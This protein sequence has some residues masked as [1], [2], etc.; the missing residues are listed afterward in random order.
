MVKMVLVNPPQSNSLDDH[1]DPPLGLMY[2]AACLERRSMNVSICDLSAKSELK[3]PDL[4]PEADIYGLTVFS[5][6]L[7]VSRRISRMIKERYRNAKIIAGGPHPTSLPEETV[8]YGEFDNVVVGEGEEIF[9]RIVEDLERGLE[10]PKVVHA[11]RIEDLDS[12]PFPARH[13]VD[14]TG[15]HREV[16]DQKATSIISSRGCAWNCNFCCKDV[17]GRKIRF[18][19]IESVCEEIS[20]VKSSYGIKSFLFYDDVL[21]LNRTRLNKLCDRLKGLDIRFRCNGRAGLCNQEDYQAL[22]EAGCEEIAFGIESGSQKMLDLINKGSTVEENERAIREA[23]RAGL[24]TKAYLVV[25][26]P[27]E[28]RETVEETKR[29]ME[30]ADPDKFTVFAFVPLPGCDVWKNPGKYGIT[31]ISKDWNQYFNIAGQYEG[32][33][34]FETQA[35]SKEEFRSLHEDLVQGLLKRGQRGRLEDYYEKLKK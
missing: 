23:K 12:L 2:I 4:I 5:A 13:M 31:T 15:Y 27:G 1:L 33:T 35:L 7:N 14:L 11:S 26:F 25:G 24:V 29:F 17:H 10:I 21:V 3:W 8:E 34:T 32:G 18:R 19:D 20:E 28:S 30:R 16:E 6:S 9:P 22:K